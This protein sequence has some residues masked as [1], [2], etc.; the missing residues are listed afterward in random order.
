MLT[1]AAPGIS[2]D[3]TSLRAWVYTK[4]QIPLAWEDLEPFVEKSIDKSFGMMASRQVYEMLCDG[5]A[6]AFVTARGN[7]IQLVAIIRF[8]Q[9]ASYGVGRFIAMAGR[10][11]RGA[12]LFLPAIEQWAVSMGCVEIEGWCRPAVTKI[13]RRLG[14]TPK[15]TLLTRDLRRKLQ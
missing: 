15:L 10:D 7:D 5:S 13:L 14:W 4:D 9:Y 11:L 8:V 6:V 2:S 12:H 1:T 3:K